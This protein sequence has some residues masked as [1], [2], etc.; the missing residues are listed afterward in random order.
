MRILSLLERMTAVAMLALLSPLLILLAVAIC[1]FSRRG[2]LVRHA[3]VG[4]R[5]APLGMLKFRTMWGRDSGLRKFRL[6]DDVSG[7]V[8]AK[9]RA[10]DCRINS[11]LALWCRRFS[12]DEL[13][14]L[15]HVVRGEM[16][17]VGPR[18]I[19]V[20]ELDTYYA[21]CVH[22]VLAVR[23][24]ITGL[25]QV[26]GRNNLTYSTRRRLDL[27]LVRNVSA[28]LYI[29]LLVRSIPSIITGKGAC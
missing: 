18:P 16:S 24:G 15:W 21:G 7:P 1:V 22:E 25:W 17:L 10:R 26:M 5:G 20:A 11:R 8:P 2:P 14:Q 29:V 27:I 4:W 23:P 6:I 13:P 9:K 12:L 3:R 19:T 28:S